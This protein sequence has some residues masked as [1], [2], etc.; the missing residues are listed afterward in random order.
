[1]RFTVAAVRL[2]GAIAL[3]L[4][5][6]AASAVC[7]ADLDER[8]AYSNRYGS[9]PYDDPRYRDLYGDDE[10]APPRA[11]DPRYSAPRYAAP[12]TIEPRYDK[13]RYGEPRYGDPGGD[14]YRPY[15]PSTKDN[16]YLPP[17][18]DPPARYSQAPRFDRDANCLPRREVHAR[19]AAGGWSSFHDI[20]IRGRIAYLKAQRPSGQLFDLE[21]DRCT[22]GII[23]AHRLEAPERPYAWRQPPYSD[24][25]Y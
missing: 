5:L 18:Q 14:D 25:R 17:M 21:I 1:M 24:R 3:T 22:G 2:I 4:P 7:A 8:G 10:P 11:A 23:A 12:R 19:L 16:G 20:D 15:P 9:S 13:P 6:A